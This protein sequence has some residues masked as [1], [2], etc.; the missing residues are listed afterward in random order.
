MR[1]GKEKRRGEIDVFRE[2][3]KKEKTRPN[4]DNSSPSMPSAIIRYNIRALLLKIT[5]NGFVNKVICHFYKSCVLRS[6]WNGF[7]FAKI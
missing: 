6:N 3:K 2:K 7:C 5:R 4:A 1:D